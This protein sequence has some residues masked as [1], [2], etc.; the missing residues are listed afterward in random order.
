MDNAT[1]HMTLTAS[2]GTSVGPFSMD[3]LAAASAVVVE[4]LTAQAATFVIAE[5]KC[6][7]SFVQR[8]LAI[9]FNKAAR[10]VENLEALG[11]VTSSDHIG[12]REV[13]VSEVPKELQLASAAQKKIQTPMKETVEDKA[14]LDKAYGQ[15]AGEI[16]S[17]VERFERLEAEKKDI[18]DNQKEVMAEAKARGY[19][20]KALRR[21]IALR[22]KDPDQRAEEEAVLET[23]M[24]ALGM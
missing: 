13:C 20:T 4:P 21:L 24:Q 19:D 10:I 15:A 9:G 12:K 14:V 6:S 11:I 22:K 23:Y 8:R 7:T 1:P 17:F 2:D 16:R 3:Q 18:T 5:Q